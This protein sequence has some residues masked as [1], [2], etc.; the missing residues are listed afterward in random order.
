MT[1]RSLT[2]LDTVGASTRSRW[3]ATHAVV[4]DLRASPKASCPVIDDH[5]PSVAR[6]L[7]IVWI[8]VTIVACS[9]LIAPSVFPEDLILAASAK[10]QGAG[11][12]PNSCMLCGMT[13]AFIGLARGDFL[14][15]QAMNRGAIPLAIAIT[16]NA[17][18]AA[19]ISTRWYFARRKPSLS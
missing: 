13:R 15:A 3:T 1:V 16:M 7:N 6:A 12:V 2:A 10:V 5:P 14:T 11:H 4:S 18:L 8:I 19:F 9:T 17:L